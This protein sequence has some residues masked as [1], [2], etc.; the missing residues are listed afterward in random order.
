MNVI[1]LSVNRGGLLIIGSISLAVHLSPS[2]IHKVIKR[3]PSILQYSLERNLE[4]KI[5]FLTS[6]AGLSGQ[7]LTKAVVASPYVLGL[8]LEKSLKPR[9]MGLRERCDL[10]AEELGHVLMRSTQLLTSNWKTNLEPKIDFLVH[11][12]GLNQSSLKQMVMSSP[13]IL[14]QSVVTSLEPKLRVLEGAADDD[15]A[16]VSQVVQENPSLLVY[17]NP[18]LAKRVGMFKFRNVTFVEAFS[19]GRRSAVGESGN[20]QKTL[21]RRLKSVLEIASDGSVVQTW[22]DVQAAALSAGTSRAN[23]YHIL[24]TGRQYNGRKYIYGSVPEIPDV[25]TWSDSNVDFVESSGKDPRKRVIPDQGD[26]SLCLG[27]ILQDSA[28][29]SDEQSSRSTIGKNSSG[30]N[31]SVF[32]SSGVYPAERRT[33]T[34]AGG[35]LMYFPQLADNHAAGKLLKIAI[36]KSIPYQVIPPSENGTNYH[37]GTVLSTYPASKPSRNRCGLFVCRSALRVVLELLA[38]DPTFT[39]LDVEVDVITDSNYIWELLG[40]P[41]A[42]LQWGSYSRAK[43]F[44]YDGPEP[45]WRV[46]SDILYPLARTYYRMRNQMLATPALGERTKPVA[47]SLMIRFRHESELAWTR[48]DSQIRKGRKLARTAAKWQFDREINA[49]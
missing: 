2:E 38:L 12:L 45:L 17:S 21:T 43:D 20:T 23:M 7:N 27:A 9:V 44:V 37:G 18:K 16:I 4:P 30:I 34:T 6:K 1:F 47:K 40:D 5:E 3:V 32:V 48:E 8:S 10:S 26:K 22:P 46:H 13:Q 42:L 25:D 24:K 15:K 28:L 14:M 35:L 36:E 39:D 41:V 19:P 31:L 11:R 33:R 49:L 29:Y